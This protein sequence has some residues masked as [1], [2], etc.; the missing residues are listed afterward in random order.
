MNTY[1]KV[2]QELKASGVTALAFFTQCYENV[3]KQPCNCNLVS[4]DADKWTRAVAGF[5]NPP[6]PYYVSRYFEKID[7]A[8]GYLIGRAFHG[9]YSSAYHRC[10]DDDGLRLVTEAGPLLMARKGSDGVWR[11]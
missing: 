2:Q 9:R 3:F 1:E 5:S 8:N 11:S 4:V 6:I 7:D 10:T